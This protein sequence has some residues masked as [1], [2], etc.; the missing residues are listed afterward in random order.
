MRNLEA[1]VVWVGLLCAVG[2]SAQDLTPRV[3]KLNARLNALLTAPADTVAP[4]DLRAGTTIGGAAIG[5]GGGA[6]TTVDYLVGTASGSLSAEIVFGA[7]VANQ[8]VTGVAAGAVTRAQ[9]DFSWLSGTATDAQ[10]NGLT[11]ADEVVG[12]ETDEALCTWETTGAK[13]DCDLVVNAG[14]NVANDLEEETHATEHQNGGGDEVA[15]ATAAANA[16]PKAGAGARLDSAWLDADLE[17]IAALPTTAYA[18]GLLDDNDAAAI[19]ATAG[20]QRADAELD[21]IIDNCILENDSTPIPDGCVGDGSDAEGGG[22]G[23][24]YANAAAATLAGF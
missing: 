20:A 6:P 1:L 17:A 2:A 8:C 10:V 16:I 23:I 4:V 13:V 24:T 15:T 14:T 7:A 22:G 5:G 12:T 19:R 21:Y 18:R 9:P 11:E 3:N